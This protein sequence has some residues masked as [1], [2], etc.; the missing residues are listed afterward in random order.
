MSVLALNPIK[1]NRM[2][3]FKSILVIKLMNLS[4]NNSDIQQVN[5]WDLLIFVIGTAVAQ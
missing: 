5:G 3:K 1:T 2:N 4:S